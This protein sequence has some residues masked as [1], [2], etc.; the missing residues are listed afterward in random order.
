[1]TDSSS[2]EYQGQLVFNGIYRTELR[3]P[4]FSNREIFEL[5]PEYEPG[6]PTKPA[7]GFAP[8]DFKQTASKQGVNDI[9]LLHTIDDI[10]SINYTY[11][12]YNSQEVINED[13]DTDM[14]YVREINDVGVYWS[15]PDYLFLHGTLHD[16]QTAIDHLRGVINDKIVI[17]PLDFSH[18]FIFW[19]LYQH[20][21]NE[22]IT[23]EFSVARLTN[24]ELVGESD[25]FGS[26][27]EIQDS[28]DVSQ[29]VPVLLGLLRGNKISSISGHFRVLGHYISAEISS[30]G[31]VHV[32][33]KGDIAEAN[34]LERMIMALSFIRVLAST[35]NKW[36]QMSPKDKNP[37]VEFFED[38]YETCVDQGVRIS[39]SLDSVIEEYLSKRGE[40]YDDVSLDFG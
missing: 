11:E 10:I 40:T 16:V 31:R 37:P 28:V 33:T 12:E 6:T 18:D 2:F 25:L 39:F 20:Y 9:G 14:A 19:L 21:Q 27:G 38:L 7:S 34:D 5:L 17:E 32:R 30:S 15:Y 4:N 36:S 13:G 22:D 3:D 8:A 29:S 35:Y 24:A 26:H 23:E 1:M